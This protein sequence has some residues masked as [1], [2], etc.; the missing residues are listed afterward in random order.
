MTFPLTLPSPLGGERRFALRVLLQNRNW[1]G[2]KPIGSLTL[3]EIAQALTAVGVTQA[4]VDAVLADVPGAATTPP[5][6]QPAAPKP[7]AVSILDPIAAE[8]ETLR[9]RIG[10][11][12]FDGDTGG[13]DTVVADL[14]RRALEAEAETKALRAAAAVEADVV[15]TP[16]LPTVTGHKTAGEVFGLPNA[17]FAGWKVAIYAPTAE[18]PR[19]DPKFRWDAGVTHMALACFRAAALGDRAGDVLLVGPAGTGKSTWA[20]Q[21]AAV[22]GRPFFEVSFSDSVEPNDLIGTVDPTYR[23]GLRWK[24][25]VFTRAIRTPGA[26][27]LFDE[28]GLAKPSSAAAF[29]AALQRRTLVI[30]ETGE[31]VDFAPGVTIVATSNDLLNMTSAGMQHFAGLRRQNMAF[32]DRFAVQIWVGHPTKTVEGAML[33]DRVH[34]MTKT[35]ST[36]LVEMASL[37]RAKLDKDEVSYGI[38]F[39]RLV[40][41]GEQLVAEVPAAAAWTNAVLHFLPESDHEVYRELAKAAGVLDD[42]VI[43]AALQNRKLGPVDQNAPGGEFTPVADETDADKS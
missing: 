43:G 32:A 29:N 35:L 22:T 7:A 36:L 34:G 2:S 17:K 4:E 21:F 3:G 18:T 38:G 28:I 25:G 40:A 1:T 42:A 37:S 13:A 31:V 11:L 14:L 27:I 24:D 39:R 5:M 6:V 23:D 8:A 20:E 30:A 10:S 19:V 12:V 41:W 26:V 33:R 9:R 16:A 15:V